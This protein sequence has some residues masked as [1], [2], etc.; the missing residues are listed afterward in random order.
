MN[1][2]Q[3]LVIALRALT[4]NKLRSFLTTLGVIIGVGAVIAMTAIGTGA[5]SQVEKSFESMGSN[6]LMVRSGSSRSGGMRGGAGSQPSITWSDLEAIKEEVPSVLYAA[7]VLSS[8]A[9]VMA[10]GQNWNTSVSG[11]TNDFF[12]IRNWEIVGGRAFEQSELKSGAKVAIVGQTVVDNLFGP[13]ADPVGSQMRVANIPFEIVGVLKKRGTGGGGH[14]QDDAIYIPERTFRAKIQGGLGQFV[15]GM[16]F[17][18]ATSKETTSLAQSEIEALL[19][20]RHRIKDGEE[21][22][23]RVRNMADMAEAM[24]QSTATMT[25][26][27]AGIAL[28]SLVVGGIGI[29]N[30]MLVSVTERT[31]EIGLRMA[32]GAKSFDILTQFLVEAAVLSTIGGALGIGAGVGVAT[33]LTSSFGWPMKV[34]PDIILVALG[35]SAAVG[36]GFG[37]WP[38]LKASRLDP[39][40]ALR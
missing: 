29:M 4:R 26:L 12:A 2:L 20:E 34:Q 24:Q 13:L 19:R 15:R 9:Q 32:I 11:T 7:P 14:D 25:S 17:V 5:Q 33:L 22:D 28:V 35:F 36:I 31:R 18:G 1:P 6:M 37:L 16:I 10:E 27:L 39:I 3:I 38:A 21:D 30:I 23:F 8:T 40:Q